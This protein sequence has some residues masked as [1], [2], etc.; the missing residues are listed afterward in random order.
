MTRWILGTTAILVCVSAPR[1]QDAGDAESD[2]TAPSYAARY[3]QVFGAEEACFEHNIVETMKAL[4]DR[5]VYLKTKGPEQHY[6]LATE[7]PCPGLRGDLVIGLTRPPS[8]RVCPHDNVVLVYS[9]FRPGQ[10]AGCYIRDIVEV[11][12]LEEAESLVE[13]LLGTGRRELE[14]SEKSADDAP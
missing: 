10:R 9:R 1:A 7:S 11:D 6:L 4:D 3:E 12:S 14:P 5:F 2:G 13:M 8:P